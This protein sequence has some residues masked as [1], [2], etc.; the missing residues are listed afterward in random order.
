M[1]KL[2]LNKTRSIRKFPLFLAFSVALCAGCVE[3]DEQNDPLTELRTLLEQESEKSVEY[4]LERTVQVIHALEGAPA[5]LKD[6]NA[7]SNY[8]ASFDYSGVSPDVIL[9]QSLMVPVVREMFDAQADREE[10]ES[11][12]R[13]FQ[14]L[15]GP[16][17]LAI[18]GAI[19]FVTSDPISG[20]VDMIKAGSSA[21]SAAIERH[22]R[23]AQVAS[24]LKNASRSYTAYLEKAS[25]AFIRHMKDW[26][27]FCTVRDQSYLAV[28]HGSYEEAL[29]HA[30][31]ALS[32][33][34]NDRE[35]ML[36]RVFSAL[37]TSSQDWP[38]ADSETV[39][40]DQ[41]DELEGTMDHYLQLYP[42]KSAPALLLQGMIAERRGESLKAII[43]FDESAV[44]YPKQAEALLEM[45]NPYTSRS[46]FGV[47]VEADFVLELYKST[48]EGF[49]AFSPNFH[50]AAIHLN[51]GD[52]EAAQEEVRMHFFRRGGQ[53][54]QDYLPTDLLFCENHIPEAIKSLFVE[55]SF[56][57][58]EIEEGG[59]L[60][61]ENALYASISNNSSR[62]LENVR[63][64]LCIHFTGTYRNTY[65]VFEIPSAINVLGPYETKTFDDPVII[66]F[67]YRGDDK[68]V[69][70]DVVH[71]RGVLVTDDIVT[72]LDSDG[73]KLK[74][75]QESTSR[76]TE[77]SDALMAL[78]EDAIIV[79]EEGYVYTTVS[80]RFPL[81][82]AKHFPY[83]S[84][85]E[86]HLPNAVYPREKRVT[87]DQVEYDF[88]T[89]QGLE[90]L[91]FLHLV[92]DM[93]SVRIPL[94]KNPS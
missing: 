81:S 26:D 46:Q 61:E 48:M 49:G 93:G 3:G 94:S 30:K 83:V 36:L 82:L 77:P 39:A 62:N 52:I 33:S 32:L 53:V 11:A 16:T 80:A 31:K 20:A 74:Q 29:G 24:R 78:V 44:L 13:A 58:I 89:T 4:N 38:S 63:L 9:A 65:E 17:S 56:V 35:S 34:P 18:G 86:V 5:N 12:W 1:M 69:L 40:V 54:V 85:N 59:L 79:S 76:E 66:D 23:D 75:A 84:L 51:N 14:D 87:A 22:E 6:F 2:K 90:E 55:K 27:Q 8:L 92:T 7:Y 72:W 71:V 91:K 50:K 64:Y 68:E 47:S 88:R 25:P 70:K 57:D 45:M 42:G 21:I 37:M 41:L 15:Q 28:H 10:N 67:T 19:S 43:L 60:D 73:F